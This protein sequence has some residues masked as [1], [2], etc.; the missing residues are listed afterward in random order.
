MSD[1]HSNINTLREILKLENRNFKIAAY[2]N[3]H[4]EA[5]ILKDMK[6]DYVYDYK[7]YRGEDF[8][9]QIH[10]KVSKDISARISRDVNT[11]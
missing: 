1:V 10:Y 7:M 8:A 9:E 3:Y 5:K 11:T 2:C 4:D 6:V